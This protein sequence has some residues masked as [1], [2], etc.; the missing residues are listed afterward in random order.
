MSTQSSS[1]PTR[2]WL[3]TTIAL[4]ALIIAIVVATLPSRVI[5]PE[6]NLE[7]GKAYHEIVNSSTIRCGFVSNPPACIVDPKTKKLSGIFVEA[8]ER[9]AEKLNLKVL[10]TEEVGFGSMIE[11]V[12]SRR[13]QMVPCAIWPNAARARHVDFSSPLYYSPVCAFVRTDDDRFV[14]DLTRIDSPDV[15]IATI[16]GEMAQAIAK[17]DFPKAKTIE[18]PQMSEI[19]MMLLNV[20]EKKADVTFAELYFA[21][22]FM[23]K[24]PG[25]LKNISGEKPI[26]IFPNTIMLKSNEPQLK[27][28]LNTALEELVNLGIVDKLIDKYE[29]ERGIFYRLSLPYRVPREA[30]K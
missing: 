14:N 18:L 15:T 28:M 30:V 19:S 29:P 13:Y 11:G 16:D 1:Y 27:A 20:K 26:R 21:H 9:A 7:A 8:I 23:K 17:S 12:E 2:G 3:P 25:S 6:E 24:N 4:F 5:S 22:E 10:W